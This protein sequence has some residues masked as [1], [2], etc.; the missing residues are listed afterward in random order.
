MKQFLESICCKEGVLLNLTYHQQR[1]DKVFQHFYPAYLPISLASITVP[2][3]HIKGTYKCRL[4][5]SYQILSLEFLPYSIRPINSLKLVEHNEINYN[6]K[7]ADR[8]ILNKLFEKRKIADDILI[9]KNGLLTDTSY[10]N[11]A[12]FDGIKWLT[13]ALPVLAGTRRAQLLD[14][15]IIHLAMIEKNDIESFQLA[16]LFNAMIPFE[17]GPTISTKNIF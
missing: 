4:V 6:H 10:A 13:P 15:G 3:T 8:T 14:D 16:R 11:I 17:K 12:L 9:V 1:L 2:P 7:Y 5:Y